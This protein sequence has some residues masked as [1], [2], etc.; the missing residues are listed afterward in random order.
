MKGINDLLAGLRAGYCLF[1]CQTFE[2]SE[3]VRDIV[4]A[5]ANFEFGGEKPYF[6]PQVWDMEINPDP[7]N[8]LDDLAVAPERTVLIA[9]NLHW[10]LKDDM[11]GLNK[12]IVQWLQNKIDL[13]SSSD[14][15]KTIIIVGDA[16]MT[17]AIPSVLQRDF[18]EVEFPLPNNGEIKKIY[19]YI[20][21][22]ASESDAFVM[23]EP[24]EQEMIL[25]YSRGM[26]KR[27]ITNAYSYAI[28]SDEGRMLP[29]TI[30]KIQAREVAKTPGL[31]ILEGKQK[32]D[33]LKGYD[34]LKAF[35]KSTIG[36]E[37]AKGIMLL[38][39]PGTGKT[40]FCTCLAA[41]SGLKMITLEMAELF[42]GLVGESEKL[43]K[44]ALDVIKANTPCIVFVDEI[45]KGLAGVGGGGQTD[46]G[47]TKRSMAQFLKFLSD[48][49]PEGVYVVAT[50]NNISQLPPEW[51]RAERWDTAP[52]FV[53]L[54]NEDERKEILNHYLKLYNV[55]PGK[56]A[57][58]NM[59]GWSGAEIRAVCR[60][61]A[62]MT[63][64]TAD[65]KDYVVPVSKTMETEIKAL[66]EWSKG[67][68][69]PASKF[70][71]PGI[72]KRKRAVTL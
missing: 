65:V 20:V 56:F 29:D 57:A 49:R 19:D 4:E 6:P 1:Y 24:L 26:T 38:G 9:K 62:M 70:T 48:S 44:Q 46:G 63:K 53:D 18:M 32:F 67:K 41:E 25:D 50:C 69:L 59:E 58:A 14:G 61:A 21:D 35:V 66:R 34:N 37:H 27:E 7:E 28:I 8:A 31:S 36:S 17:E 60:I 71:M 2:M 68:T 22:S 16:T 51:V 72:K 42:G 40:H 45:E 15:R 43:M 23:P 12:Q 39:P 54:P 30:G 64:T 5:L 3:T 52:F 33:S 13:F 11:G 10:F 55:E 47:T